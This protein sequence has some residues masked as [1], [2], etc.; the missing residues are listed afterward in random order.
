MTMNQFSENP[1]ESPP[2]RAEVIVPKR[3]ASNRPFMQTWWPY[4]AA[5]TSVALM[6]SLGQKAATFACL[7]SLIALVGIEL[8]RFYR[9]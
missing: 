8:D 4:F 5:I 7:A 6:S 3:A 1:Y 9:A 2:I